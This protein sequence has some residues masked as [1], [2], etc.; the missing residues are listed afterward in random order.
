[1]GKWKAPITIIWKPG[2][3]ARIDIPAG[4]SLITFNAQCGPPDRV[5][6][7]GP[8]TIEAST[9][10]KDPRD[11]TLPT[12]FAIVPD[13]DVDDWLA[14]KADQLRRV[15]HRVSRTIVGATRAPGRA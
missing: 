11:P 5:P 1:M 15:M 13:R 9:M 2:Q 7:T 10:A 4:H 3:T 12:V 14:L 6:L 8:K